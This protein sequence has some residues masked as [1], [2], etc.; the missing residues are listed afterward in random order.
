MCWYYLKASPFQ[1]ACNVD[2][3]VDDSCDKLGVGREACVPGLDKIAHQECQEMV[4]LG[5]E[6]WM[7][8]IEQLRDRLTLLNV[9][10]EKDAQV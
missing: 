7:G 4:R 1:L 5:I 8:M 3:D 2:Y 9:S 10:R 6:V